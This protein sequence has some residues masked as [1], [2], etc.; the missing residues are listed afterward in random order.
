MG[1]EFVM[2]ERRLRKLLGK[3]YLKPLQIDSFPVRRSHSRTFRK[4]VSVRVLMV[5]S[6]LRVWR[7][8][9]AYST[10]ETQNPVESQAAIGIARGSISPTGKRFSLA[11]AAHGA[12]TIWSFRTH[13]LQQERMRRFF[14]YHGRLVVPKRSSCPLS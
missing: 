14:R 7:K 6:H 2:I 8:R 1:H 11:I 10:A 12:N 9:R 13:R 4:F 5:R 3:P